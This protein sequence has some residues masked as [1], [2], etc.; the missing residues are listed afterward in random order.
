MFIR[1]FICRVCSAEWV[2]SKTTIDQ[3]AGLVLARA[4]WT[5]TTAVDGFVGALE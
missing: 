5:M 1:L 2:I 3:L 4:R